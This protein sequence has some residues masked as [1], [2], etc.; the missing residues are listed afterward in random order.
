MV[1]QSACIVLNSFVTVPR[2]NLYVALIMQNEKSF[3]RMAG[4]PFG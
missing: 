2:R 3:I 4:K 1:A